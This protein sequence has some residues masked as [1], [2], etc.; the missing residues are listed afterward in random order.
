LYS[1]TWWCHVAKG[2]AMTWR[3]PMLTS[4]YCQPPGT[5]GAIQLQA[6]SLTW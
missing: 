2:R 5:Q 6:Y 4:A 3:S 1:L